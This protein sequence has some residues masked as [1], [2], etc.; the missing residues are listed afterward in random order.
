[1][2][3]SW[4]TIFLF[5]PVICKWGKQDHLLPTK[6]SLS[7]W[8][9]LCFQL[10]HLRWPL[11]GAR[12]SESM[13]RLLPK[14]RILSIPRCSGNKW[15][16]WPSLRCSKIPF[17]LYSSG[18]NKLLQLVQIQ[19]NREIN[20]TFWCEEEYVYFT[21]EEWIDSGYLWTSYIKRISTSIFTWIKTHLMT[22]WELYRGNTSQWNIC[23]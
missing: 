19:E 18:S 1:M 21:Q 15:D 8:S 17:S 9:I 16:L 7:N 2:F 14:F 6:C 13:V 5:V 20:S 12:V 10:I 11:H 23:Q 4:K 3:T 22:E